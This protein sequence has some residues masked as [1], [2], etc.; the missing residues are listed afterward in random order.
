MIL[1][2]D[3]EMQDINNIDFCACDSEARIYLHD[4]LLTSQELYDV[5]KDEK[6]TYFKKHARVDVYMLQFCYNDKVFIT[7]DF[8]EFFNTLALFNVKVCWWYNAKYDYAHIEYWLLTNG[9]ECVDKITD[10]KQ[11]TSLHS[12]YGQR[13][14]MQIGI[15][16]NNDIHIIN[17][18]DFFNFFGYGLNNVAKSFKVLDDKNEQMQKLNVIDYQEKVSIEYAKQDVKML[19]KIVKMYDN[20]IFNLY[21]ERLGAYHKYKKRGIV[22][23][24]TSG[25]LAKRQL[26]KSMYKKYNYASYKSLIRFYKNDY[27]ISAKFDKKC[28]IF[29]L[30]RGGLTHINKNFRGK[31]ITNKVYKYDINS[32]Y[33]YTMKYSKFPKGY[34]F[35][36]K[37]SNLHKYTN[38]NYIV[39][40]VFNSIVAQ[41]KK[42][43]LPIF[44]DITKGD[45][46]EKID[47]NNQQFFMLYNE[48]IEMLHWYNVFLYDIAYIYVYDK[49]IDSPYSDFIDEHYENKQMYENVDVIKYANGKLFLNSC[50]GK[51]GENPER[52]LCRFTLNDDGII[53]NKVIDLIIN[54]KN[55]MNVLHASIIT[56]NARIHLLSS[57]RKITDNVRRDIIY[58]DTDSIHTLVKMPKNMI[59]N[60]KLGYFKD[61]TE[62]S[63]YIN[64]IYLAP[65]TYAN[66]E[67]ENN[68]IN[69]NKSTFSTKGINKQ[70]IKNELHN[71]DINYL[72]KRFNY[73]QTFKSLMAINCLGGKALVTVDKKLAKRDKDLVLDYDDVLIKFE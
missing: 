51:I 59:D 19:Y 8:E 4:K 25:G 65:K 66:I 62:N 21:G 35:T 67:L 45:Y 56:S 27:P 10:K 37:A 23:V 31:L 39:I 73:G 68:K 64:N 70:T 63:N 6:Y 11:Y 14:K 22:T 41:C 36:D 42:N 26:L 1:Y 69:S 52:E 33:P 50:Y 24:L 15:Q 47:F 71:K 34:G 40:L 30:Y 49:I 54:D 20:E 3:F 28:R 38:D 72:V 60:K 17:M 53:S 9:Y 48:W 58:C 55:T 2:N 7:D 18:Y 13:Y 57:M 12:K 43:M 32:M 5:T 46:S 29:G 61:E 16:I 44:W